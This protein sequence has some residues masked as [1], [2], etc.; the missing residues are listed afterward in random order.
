MK[1]TE[2]QFRAVK[3]MSNDLIPLLRDIIERAQEQRTKDTA[4]LLI[5][6]VESIVEEF[7]KVEDVSEDLW[8][9]GADT[10]KSVIFFAQQMSNEVLK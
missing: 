1:K 7:E 3:A 2:G 9:R 6:D 10:I 8:Q 4:N 5:Y